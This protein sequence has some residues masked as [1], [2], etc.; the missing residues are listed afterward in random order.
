MAVS[1]DEVG[2]RDVRSGLRFHSLKGVSSDCFDDHVH[3]EIDDCPASNGESQVSVQ[4]LKESLT[5]LF[6]NERDLS[7]LKSWLFRP[8][9]ET[10]CT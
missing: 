4:T 7:V 3:W 6:D 8:A 2:A 5:I 10:F 9:K 1:P